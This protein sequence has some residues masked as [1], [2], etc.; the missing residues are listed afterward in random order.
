MNA[1]ELR[2]IA[3][4]YNHAK[5]M[6]RQKELSSIISRIESWAE[7]EARKGNYTDTIETDSNFRDSMSKFKI[8]EPEIAD[9]LREEGFGVA[10]KENGDMIVTWSGEYDYEL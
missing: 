5:E 4:D 10:V 9:M 1:K 6:E 8:T 2:K 7:Q 3:N